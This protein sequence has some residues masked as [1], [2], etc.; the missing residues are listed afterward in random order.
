[1]IRPDVPIMNSSVGPN[2]RCEYLKLLNEA[3]ARRVWIAFDRPTLFKDRTDDLKRL[4]E[5]LRFFEENGLEVGVWVQAFG[6]GDDLPNDSRNC[7]WTRIRSVTGSVKNGDAFCPED[8]DFVSAYTDWIT[9]IA[10]LSPKFIMLDDD[11]CLSVRPGIGCFC[12]KH[13]NLLQNEVGEL[14]KLTDIFTGGKNKYRDAWYKVMGNT[15]KSFCRKVR[16]AV[17]GVDPFIRIGI[18]AGYTSWDIEGCDPIEL[19]RI[20]AGST[21]PFFRLT[22]APYWVAPKRNRFYGQRLSAVIENARNQIAWC[23]DS[24]VEF[25]AEADSYPR[26]AYN[27][28][29]M[30]V[31]NFDIA[32]HASSVRSL[33]YLFDYVSSASYEKQYLNIHCYNLPLYDRIENAF[34]DSTP[35]G[36]K[37]Y[38][39]PHRILD[40]VLPTEFIGEKS[41]MRTYF[42]EAAAMLACH[43]IPVCYGEDSDFAA[44]FGNDAQYF[45]NVH[46]KVLLDISAA[47][48]LKEKGIDVGIDSVKDAKIPR[49]ELFDGEKIPLSQIYPNAKFK[50]LTLKDGAVIRSVFDTQAVACFEY[51]NFMILSFD[52]LF[53]NESSE[54]FCSY[55]R[56]KQLWEFFGNPY[57][58]VIGYSEIYSICAAKNNKLV[59]LFQNHSMDPIYGLE[60]TLPKG[61]TSFKLY[62]V[63]AEI[64]GNKISLTDGFLPQSTLLLEV[65]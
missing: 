20:L 13:I 62:G 12:D 23:K 56:G 46:Q 43:A 38:R 4:G 44:V 37:V 52:A 35:C 21:E 40:A 2:N 1:M 22:S 54:L 58:S 51:K 45:E 25:F 63:G 34:Q 3:K 24:G 61:Y 59:S 41:V 28:P 29:A 39:P 48:F 10:R 7:H 31:E 64:S 50:D 8:P 60:I 27:C 9:D 47:L 57:P 33:K 14:P 5:N 6:F 65:E 30:I 55:E 32:M 26:P 53:V 42:S 49:F 19:S 18:C 17:D 15:L 16:C 11:L 36:V